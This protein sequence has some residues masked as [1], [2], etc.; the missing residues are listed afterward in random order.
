MY[1]SI[2]P[3][4]EEDSS[5]S[6]DMETY[7]EVSKEGRYGNLINFATLNMTHDPKKKINDK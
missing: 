7:G 5:S 3:L 2:I 1:Q 6:L 4:N